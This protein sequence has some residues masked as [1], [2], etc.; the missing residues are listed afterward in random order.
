MILKLVGATAAISVMV[1]AQAGAAAPA[2]TSAR[3]IVSGPQSQQAIDLEQD[4]FGS[5]AQATLPDAPDHYASAFAYAF[6]GKLGTSSEVA[7]NNLVPDD[8]F[9]NAASAIAVASFTDVLSVASIDPVGYAKVTLQISGDILGFGGATRN[10]GDSRL[11]VAFSATSADGQHFARFDLL[12]TIFANP[13]T[14]LAE[15]TNSVTTEYLLGA[16]LEYSIVNNPAN[17]FDTYEWLFPFDASQPWTFVGS[18]SCNSFT[19]ANVSDSSS[20][21]CSAAHS[22]TWMGIA[23]LDDNFDPV[24]DAFATSASGQNYNIEYAPFTGGAVPEPASWAM[25]VTGFGLVGALSR[26]RVRL[27]A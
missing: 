20:L 24:A 1:A 22:A 19:A 21:V 11:G 23:F 3:V 25:L 8:A 18:M 12:S 15:T 7:L 26:R 9:S 27:A 14:G 2:H 13:V 5:T 17:P 4:L 6:L 16:N 10:F